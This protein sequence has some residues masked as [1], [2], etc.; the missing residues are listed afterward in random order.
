MQT[1]S[2]HS[3]PALPPRRIIVVGNDSVVSRALQLFLR[4]EGYDT[5]AVGEELE[6]PAGARVL[7]SADLAIVASAVGT[8]PRAEVCRQLKDDPSLS[9]LPVIALLDLE[10][11]RAV[12]GADAVLTWPYR[13]REV[14][15]L[16]EELLEAQ[17]PGKGKES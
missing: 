9:R 16:V 1:V 15:V 3:S 12:P 10:D 11:R 13:L 14:L 5:A 7:G 17:R 2:Q 6:G 4:N 8:R